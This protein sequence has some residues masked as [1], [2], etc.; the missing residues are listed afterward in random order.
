MDCQQG[1]LQVQRLAIV[2]ALHLK[3][4]TD[5]FIGRRR[6]RL[7]ERYKCLALLLGKLFNLA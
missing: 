3:K 6:Q 2:P 1:R 5:L 4:C 7:K